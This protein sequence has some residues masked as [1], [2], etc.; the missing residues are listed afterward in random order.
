MELSRKLWNR[1]KS[2]LKSKFIK[3]KIRQF[4]DRNIFQ[5][6][7]FASARPQSAEWTEKNS[8]IELYP[9]RPKNVDAYGDDVYVEITARIKSSL[10]DSPQRARPSMKYQDNWI[11]F[12]D[13]DTEENILKSRHMRAYNNKVLTEVCFKNLVANDKFYN[14]NVSKE[15]CVLT[16]TFPEGVETDSETNNEMRVQVEHKENREKEFVKT[17]NCD[18]E[19]DWILL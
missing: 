15:K 19:D 1:T 16:V 14:S 4:C 18:S 2:S 8:D 6:L 7:C 10:E 17:S 11:K 9:M 5:K 13:Y 12:D 3:L